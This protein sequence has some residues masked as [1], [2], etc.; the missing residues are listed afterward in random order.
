MHSNRL[1]VRAAL[2]AAWRGV[3]QPPHSAKLSTFLTGV[4]SCHD[5]ASHTSDVQPCLVSALSGWW[6]GCG[7]CTCK[8][9]RQTH[10]GPCSPSSSRLR[11]LLRSHYHR[12]KKSISSVLYLLLSEDE[13]LPSLQLSATRWTSMDSWR[14]NSSSLLLPSLDIA[15]VPKKLS[16]SDGRYWRTLSSTPIMTLA[17]QL[18]W[19]ARP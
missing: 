19:W 8:C 16:S 14:D 4:C 9:N 18:K 2:A 10:L 7:P 17:A 12:Q 11:V 15:G 3:W 5:L 13:L 6:S 1:G